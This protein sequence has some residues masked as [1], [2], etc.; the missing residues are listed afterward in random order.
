LASSPRKCTND[1][2]I[3]Q[4]KPRNTMDIKKKKTGNQIGAAWPKELYLLFRLKSHATSLLS[5]V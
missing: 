2:T 3:Q 1:T 5:W 4:L